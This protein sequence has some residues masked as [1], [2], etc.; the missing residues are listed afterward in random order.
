MRAVILRFP[1]AFASD[2]DPDGIYAT[3]LL[4]SYIDDFIGGADS[5]EQARHQLSIMASLG[6]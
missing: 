2:V 6:E 3:R 5:I 1:K 4:F